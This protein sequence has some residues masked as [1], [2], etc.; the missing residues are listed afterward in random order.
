[1]L[2]AYSRSY[3]LILV[4]AVLRAFGTALTSTC[5]KQRL[6]DSFNFKIYLR[7]VILYVFQGSALLR[8]I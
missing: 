6:Y 5:G 2:L 8:Y 7:S 3:V 4:T 1:M